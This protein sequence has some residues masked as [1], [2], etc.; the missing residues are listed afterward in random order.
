MESADGWDPALWAEIGEMGWTGLIVP[1]DQGGVG[2]SWVALVGLLEETGRALLCS[3]LLGTVIG[4]AALLVAD[5]DDLP[6]SWLPAL[7]SGEATAAVRLGDGVQARQHGGGWV[8][9]GVLPHVTHGLSADLLVIEASD[10]LFVVRGEIAE[11]T[12]LAPLD[13]T[14]PQAE[15]HLGGAPARRLGPTALDRVRDLA[16]V[17]VA[18][19]QAGGA[20]ACLEMAVD[21]AKMREQF[22]RAIGTF[23]AVQHMCADMMVQAESARSAAWYAGWA[24]AHDEAG[25]PQAAAAARAYCCDAYLHNAGQNIQ[26]H[27]GIGFTWEHDA[28]LHLK[29]ARSTTGIMGLGDARAWRAR[30]AD[31]KGI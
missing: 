2:L 5:A 18:A 13:L 15:V 30:Y 19:E 1:V 22:G 12:A 25:L 6:S 26:V 23:Q 17:A 20:R 14:R 3:P 7:A 11:R 8:V 31:A 24:A 9:T 4:Q 28:H 10:G 21:Y 29:R 27:G 16:A